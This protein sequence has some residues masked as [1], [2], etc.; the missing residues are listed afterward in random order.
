MQE[1]YH[2]IIMGVFAVIGGYKC[3]VINVTP[4]ITEDCIINQTTK[5]RNN[6]NPNI[7]FENREILFKPYSIE[8]TDQFIL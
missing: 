5:N 6:T 3:D 1:V 4:V 8:L 2:I 7:H